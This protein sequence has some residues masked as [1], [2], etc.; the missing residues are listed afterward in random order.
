MGNDLRERLLKWQRRLWT[1]NVTCIV[2]TLLTY[3][4]NRSLIIYCITVALI[5]LMLQF[6]DVC[7]NGHPA[8]YMYKRRISIIVSIIG[9]IVGIIFV[10]NIII[11]S[12]KLHYSEREN[13][14]IWAPNA[15]LKAWRIKNTV[16]TI[17]QLTGQV[18]AISSNIFYLFVKF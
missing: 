7:T 1:L 15:V 16:E 5:P 12:L 13:L 8:T 14:K 4:D 3:S 2:L 9:S 10:L 17:W 6:Y 11:L 18:L